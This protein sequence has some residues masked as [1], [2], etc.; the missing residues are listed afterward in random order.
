[1]D[2]DKTIEQVESLYQS[3]TGQALPKQDRVYAP[4]NPNENPQK[5]V[6]RHI[7]LLLETL[8]ASGLT[9]QPAM[10]NPPIAVWEN[11]VEFLL[12]MDL[13]G[14]KK[15]DID[16]SIEGHLFTIRGV[17]RPLLQ[18]DKYR[19]LNVEHVVGPFQRSIMLPANTTVTKLNSV[20]TDGVMEIRLPKV[21][22][23]SEPIQ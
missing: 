22:S 13:P 6:E 10:W 16:I 14:V 1:M 3:V 5:Q 19:A 7:D 8:Q 15:E 4:L 23:K 12:R 11:E 2:I 18:E 17:R 9:Q 21:K 20:V